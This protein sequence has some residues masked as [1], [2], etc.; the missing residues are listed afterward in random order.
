MHVGP[1]PLADWM[2]H[3]VGLGTFTA[4]S[5]AVTAL[6]LREA[7]RKAP[8]RLRYQLNRYAH[9]Q[10]CPTQCWGGAARGN[11]A[12]MTLEPPYGGSLQ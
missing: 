8:P 10:W 4:L 11:D 1:G 12:S 2:R 9:A 5:G 3:V 7:A 6:D